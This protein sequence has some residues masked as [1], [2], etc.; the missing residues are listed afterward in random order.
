[1]GGALAPVAD[2]GLGS[3]G[4]SRSGVWGF[5]S[6]LSGAWQA[7][8]GDRVGEKR[9]SGLDLLGCDPGSGYAARGVKW[10]EL[11]LAYRSLRLRD[12]LRARPSS[13][14]IKFTLGLSHLGRTS[15]GRTGSGD[16]WPDS[17]GGWG[18]GWLPG[19]PP[20]LQITP[21]F[22]WRWPAG[23]PIPVPRPSGVVPSGISAARRPRRKSQGRVMP[24]STCHTP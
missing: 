9:C 10:R 12:D 22:R 19:L 18:T 6:G 2:H 15:A 1:M 24:P 14:L 4:R 8:K 5:R 13:S 7:R 20:Q 3:W 11:K 23:V 21:L 16:P 17:L